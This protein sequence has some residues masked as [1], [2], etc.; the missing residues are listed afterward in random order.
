MLMTNRS[1]IKPRHGWAT[2]ALVALLAL[3]TTTASAHV[4]DPHDAEARDAAVS[5][6]DAKRVVRRFLVDLGYSMNARP[7]GARIRSV[8]RDGDTWVVQVDLRPDV[9][10][11]REQATLYVDAH[12]GRL[13]DKAPH[14]SPR[15]AAQ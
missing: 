2:A 6:N 10:I 15:V 14:D 3:G 13:T 5:A 8:T 11:R 9:T 1:Y 12:S 7:G 4:P